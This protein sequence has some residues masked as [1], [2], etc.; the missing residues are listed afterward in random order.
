[1]RRDLKE[2]RTK[3]E[4]VSNILLRDIERF[5]RNISMGLSSVFDKLYTMKK[6]NV[7]DVS[8]FV[9]LKI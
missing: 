2:L 9:D 7:E 5:K 1:M 6:K 4:T 8:V 3:C